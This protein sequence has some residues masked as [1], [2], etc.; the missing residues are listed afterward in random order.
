MTKTA[1]LNRFLLKRFSHVTFKY[2][3]FHAKNDTLMYVQPFVLDFDLHLLLLI[4]IL[5]V[6]HHDYIIWIL[7]KPSNWLAGGSFHGETRSVKLVFKPIVK[8]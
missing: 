6:S 4:W 7:G 2:N 8:W 5:C 3:P 1:N